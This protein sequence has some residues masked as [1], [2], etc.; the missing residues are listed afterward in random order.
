MD[1]PLQ[2]ELT[3]AE[4]KLVRNDKDTISIT[5][6]VFMNCDKETME[7]ISDRELDIKDLMTLISNR[8]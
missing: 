7:N 2:I 6:S 5:L 8:K 4:I 3:A 1:K